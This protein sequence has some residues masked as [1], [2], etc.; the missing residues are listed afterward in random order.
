MRVG[1]ARA[2][3]T[4]WVTQ[5]ASREPGFAGAFFSGSTS[6]LT[7]EVE[8]PQVSDVDVVV[9]IDANVAPAKLGMFR[10]HGPLLD[11]SYLTW[12]SLGPPAEVL[13]SYRLAGS[14]RYDTIIADPTGRLGQLHEQVSRDFTRRA[15]V[16]H[17]CADAR[18]AVGAGLRGVGAAAT[19][20]EQVTAWWFA[21][22][23]TAHL[24]LVAALRHPT[25][26]LRYVAA[27]QVLADYGHADFYP[28]LL[29]LLGCVHLPARRVEHHLRALAETFDATVAVSRSEFFFG[30]DITPLA[31]P[32]AIG[33]SQQLIDRGRHR[34]AMF[35]IVATFARCHMTL[36]T[37]APRSTRTEL[38]P[39]FEA[40]L[41][42]LGLAS[43]EDLLRRAG[44]VTRFLPRVWEITEKILAANTAIT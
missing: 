33:G 21:T 6:R 8:L 9:V 14:F 36:A 11:V 5:Y 29:E 32:I 41:A 26:R 35:W 23:A 42:D 22:G 16:R 2:A 43:T 15:W 28:D 27:R 39:A 38:V 44:D 3:A 1:L 25:V 4:R 18:D 40:V 34:E 24:P 7:D 30:T 19:F 10:Y 12:G 37:D 13:A 20:A 17:R 31:R